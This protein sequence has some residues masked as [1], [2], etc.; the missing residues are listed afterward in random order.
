MKLEEFFVCPKCK[1]KLEI[2]EQFY[3]CTSCKSSYPV[4]HNIPVFMTGNTVSNVYSEFW[5][6]G[7]QRRVGEGGNEYYLIEENR[8]QLKDK[9]RE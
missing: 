8:E 4:L 9:E 3:K 5:D 2:T 6:N 7:W 1:I